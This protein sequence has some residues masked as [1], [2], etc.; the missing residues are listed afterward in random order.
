MALQVSALLI[1][2]ALLLY[3]T[4]LAEPLRTYDSK[5]FNAQ[6]Q[7]VTLPGADVAAPT[8]QA[9]TAQ[10]TDLWTYLGTQVPS[11]QASFIAI[12]VSSGIAGLVFAGLMPKAARSFWAATL[13]TGLFVSAGWAM[14]S[15]LWPELRQSIGQWGILI[16]AGLWAV[17]LVWNM[18]DLIGPRRVAP[19]AT[20][21][22]QAAA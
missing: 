13:G 4:R 19:P 18:V 21:A 15:A 8:S 16:A 5:D 7:Q 20:V 22:E 3:G 2:G 17:S 9:L 14:I 11:F 1:V 10:L 12:V 6:S